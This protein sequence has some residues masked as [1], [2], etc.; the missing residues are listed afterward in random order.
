M[1]IILDFIWELHNHISNF[2]LV[3]LCSIF[4]EFINTKIIIDKTIE[5]LVTLLFIK[6]LKLHTKI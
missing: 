2:S 5:L 4:I 3:D 6:I 1:N